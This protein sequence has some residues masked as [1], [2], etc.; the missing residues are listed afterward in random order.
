MYRCWELAIKTA[1]P[2]SQK[3]FIETF[4]D[5]LNSVVDQAAD[6]DSQTVRTIDSYLKTRRENIGARPSFVNGILHLELPDEAFYHPLITELVYHIADLL[7]LDNVRPHLRY[8]EGYVERL[9]A[10]S[11]LSTGHCFLQQGTGYWGRSSQ[12]PYCRNAPIQH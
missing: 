10:F 4:T 12:H 11:N 1:T 3:H 8:K 2:S 5:Y 7:I 6:R 9:I